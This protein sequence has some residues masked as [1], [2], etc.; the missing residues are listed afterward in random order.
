MGFFVAIFG[1]LFYG[2]FKKRGEEGE[3]GVNARMVVEKIFGFEVPVGNTQ[4][5]E[6]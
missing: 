2:C 6:V 3:P 1:G 4:A 5:V